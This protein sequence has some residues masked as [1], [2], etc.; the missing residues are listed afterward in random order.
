LKLHDFGIAMASK[1]SK[2]FRNSLVIG[3]FLA[4]SWCLEASASTL[5]TEN[6]QIQITSNCEEGNVVCNDITYVFTDI[7]A[8]VTITRQGRTVHRL[9]ADQVTPCQFLG[10]EFLNSEY[11]DPEPGMPIGDYS[12]IE[13]R[14]F[15]SDDGLLQIYRNQQLLTSEQ[16]TWQD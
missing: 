13:Y 7:E 9:C 5:R 8:A 12:P 16:G 15:I 1:H 2:L 10:Y 6:F 3:A 11:E 14:Y 4:G